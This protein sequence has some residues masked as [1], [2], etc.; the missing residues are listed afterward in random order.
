MIG[1]LCFSA[2]AR[3]RSNKSNFLSIIFFRS[4]ICATK[5][6]RSALILL[7]KTWYS[8][9]RMN[10]YHV[11]FKRINAERFFFVAQMI[12]LKKMM[13]KKFD[14]LDRFRAEAEKQSSPITLSMG[15]AYGARSLD[16]PLS[17]QLGR[18]RGLEQHLNCSELLHRFHR[19]ILRHKQSPYSRW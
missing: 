17:R 16:E 7:K 11:F 1:E 15:I 2:S 10:E 9:I 19:G 12:D 18:L 4:I 8:F 14:L 13:D 3:K 6:N 5:K